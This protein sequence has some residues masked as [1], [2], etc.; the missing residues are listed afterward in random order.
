MRNIL[1]LFLFAV[2]YSSCSIKHDTDHIIKID[3]DSC[4]TNN[5]VSIYDIFDKIE[6]I[7]LDDSLLTSNTVYSGATNITTDGSNFYLLD[8]KS[9][10]VNVYSQ[11]GKSLYKVNNVGRGPGEYTM[12]AQIYY[13]NRL[14]LIEILN[15]IG[16]VLRYSCDSL[17]FVSELNFTGGPFATHYI[18]QIDEYYYLYSHSDEEQLY[19]LNES[20]DITT[21]LGYNSPT[22]LRHYMAASSGVFKLY[23]K[24]CIF[25]PYDGK[26][27]TINT[28]SKSLNPLLDWD[29][30]KY[31][32][33][34][35]DI[36]KYDDARKYEDFIINYSQ[37]H[38]AAFCSISG[39]SE[40]IFATLIFKGDI[41]TLVYNIIDNT[42][43]LF[44]K[45]SEG[46]RFLPELFYENVMYKFVDCTSLTSFINKDIL[47]DNS[48][49]IFDQINQ[50]DGCGIIK[51]TLK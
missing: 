5:R 37:N 2:I 13:N 41:Y 11:D 29:M 28:E 8:C 40:Q 39:T 36:P 49:K 22:H 26:V 1:I 50:E 25:R 33:E 7:Q 42:Y 47:D 32:C 20:S 45:T 14:K 10:T 23:D 19:M 4:L 35:K 31:G 16:K 15:P 34:L 17:K 43:Q 12:A 27:F 18:S 38:I 46:M 21:P 3:V 6:L 51:Y 48:Q 24:P 44:D 9:L 30:G